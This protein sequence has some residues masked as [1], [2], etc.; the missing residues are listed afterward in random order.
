MYTKEIVPLKGLKAG[1]VIFRDHSHPLAYDDGAVYLHRH[2]ASIKLGRWV[3][4]EEYVHHIDEN[5]LNNEPYN[6]EILSNSEHSKI[7]NPNNLSKIICPTCKKE[8][9]PISCKIQYCSPKCY[10][11]TTIKNTK[12]TKEL[13]DELIPKTSWRDLGNMFG[14]SDNGIKKRAKALGCDTSNAK[15]KRMPARPNGEVHA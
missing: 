9:Q 12:I 5:K 10:A 8:F 1:Y 11:V 15:N 4:S 2:V 3:T 13:L 14:Y 6:L 7:H